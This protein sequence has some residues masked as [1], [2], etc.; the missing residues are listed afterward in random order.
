MN[1]Q[2]NT[3]SIPTPITSHATAPNPHRTVLGRAG[4]C[5]LAL[6]LSAGAVSAA[7]SVSP[8]IAYFYGDGPGEG[9]SVSADGRF[10]MV[11]SPVPLNDAGTIFASFVPRLVHT[12]LA[13][14]P[15]VQT[16]NFALGFGEVTDVAVLPGDA[17]GL[18]VVRGDTVSPLNALLAVRG[19]RI[20][21]TLPIPEKPDG[22]KVSP[23]GRYAVVAVE[24][25]GEIR[26]Y[27][28]TGGAGQIRLAALITR[29]AL[30]AYYDGVDNPV[31]ALEPEAVGI[32]SD[33]S[34][35]LVTIQ[36][37]SSVAAVDLTVVAPGEL[38]GLT[39]EQIGDLALKN[40]VHLPYGF[41]GSD[42]KLYGVEPDGVGISPDKSFAMLAHEVTQ[43]SKHLAGFSVLDLTGGL[44]N[45]TAHT[46]CIFD[47]D[48]TLLANTGLAECP[49]VAPGGGYPKAANAL[50]RL[51]PASV[52]IVQRGGQ[53]VAALVIERYDASAA[54]K[55][56]ASDNESRGSVLFLDVAQAL[57]GTFGVIQRV[58]AGVSG[59][60][61]EVIDSAEG[62]RWIFVSISNG[63]GSKGTLARLELTE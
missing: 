18:A 46:Y 55:A 3:P 24:K 38:L 7:V 25:G 31:D 9:L 23:D 10:I 59:S 1:A 50:P 58:P 16:H 26:I 22:M 29:D 41:V 14:L 53:T 44:E 20:V 6:L 48:P 40:V 4:R 51:D 47:V 43:R 19:N 57:N 21:Q 34:F 8:T 36:D 52:K 39:P 35:A 13:P 32:A 63:G 2:H 56:A 5:L 42:G 45:I 54:Q 49:V 30:A 61:L 11:S 17:F 62:G 15:F 27:D 33:S 37:S 28:L 12:P 60:R